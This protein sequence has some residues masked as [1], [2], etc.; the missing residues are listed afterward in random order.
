MAGCLSVCLSVCL[1]V[2]P[3][4]IAV[5]IAALLL[6]YSYDTIMYH[7]IM[8]R[9]STGFNLSRTVDLDLCVPRNRAPFS[10]PAAQSAHLQEG[11][12]LIRAVSRRGDN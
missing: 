12:K 1:C 5:P 3:A 6:C 8:A 11:L 2:F 10:E 7:A 4:I 9:D